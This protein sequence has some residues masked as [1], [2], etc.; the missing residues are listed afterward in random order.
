MSA[1]SRKMP[2]VSV[3]HGCCCAKTPDGERDG[4]AVDRVR[5]LRRHVDVSIAD[6]L[7]PCT[8][9]DVLVVRPSPQ[10]RRIGGRPTWLARSGDDETTALV[11]AWIR[12]G[13]PGIAEVP[14]ELADR[15]FKPPRNAQL[16]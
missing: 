15:R 3:C 8:E 14:P 1:R 5:L 2:A 12:A 9:K 11:L 13:G 4:A 10:G 6:C 16:P 7:G